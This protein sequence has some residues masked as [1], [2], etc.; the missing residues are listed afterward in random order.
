M[1]NDWHVKPLSRKSS[2]SG[3]TF[4]EGA[5][6]VCHIYFSQENPS[7]LVRKDILEE[8]LE[9]FE[10]P[11]NLIAKWVRR[12]NVNSDVEKKEML[13]NAEEL[14]FSLFD[15]NNIVNDANIKNR[16]DIFRQLLGL[17]LERKRI[18][19]RMTTKDKGIILYLHSTS[20]KIYEVS[21]T[22]LDLEEIL[23]LQ[24]QLAMLIV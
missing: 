2:I 9:G 8:E 20:K 14:F 11:R 16:Q 22:N 1:N 12:V 21:E 10:F 7:E 17:M 4:E 23:K 6:V 3:E 15:S 5:R 24:E 18:L 19:K 13:N